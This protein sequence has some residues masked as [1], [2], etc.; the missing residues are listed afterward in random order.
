MEKPN[1]C[2]VFCQSLRSLDVSEDYLV[3]FSKAIQLSMSEK[4]SIG[5]ALSES[6]NPDTRMCG[7]L[8]FFGWALGVKF[9]FS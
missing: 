5:L 1:F 3:N 7:M 4:I 6:E 9:L 2:T 8:Q